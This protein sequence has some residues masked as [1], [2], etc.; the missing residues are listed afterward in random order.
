M[1]IL[2]DAVEGHGGTALKHTGDGMR[3]VPDH[4]LGAAEA[5]IA[6]Q[7]ALRSDPDGAHRLRARMALHTGPCTERDGDLF[8]P[9]LN[10]AARI[11]AAAHGGQ[12]VVS[13]DVG[14]C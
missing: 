11:M 6:A 14:A 8:G 1:L 4:P 2:R 3:P 7:R 12:I 10:R 13:F 9:T 5:A